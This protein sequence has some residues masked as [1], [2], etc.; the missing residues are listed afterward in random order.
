MSTSPTDSMR[1]WRGCRSTFGG[2]LHQ[3]G[4][5]HTLKERLEDTHRDLAYPS[6]TDTPR[7]KEEIDQL[8][9]TDRR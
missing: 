4:F 6:Q 7:I 9:G 3:R 5:L 2:A 1:V 8:V